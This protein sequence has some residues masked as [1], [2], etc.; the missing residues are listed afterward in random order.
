MVHQYMMELSDRK[1]VVVEAALAVVE[2]M[3]DM[4]WHHHREHPGQEELYTMAVNLL[5]A[6][7]F[8]L[9]LAEES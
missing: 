4:E 5:A 9:N 6:L 2:A 7:Q 3:E 8:S 1:V